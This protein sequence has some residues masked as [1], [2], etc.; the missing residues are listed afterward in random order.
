MKPYFIKDGDIWRLPIEGSIIS[1]CLVDM[2]FTFEITIPDN[3][4][5][6]SVK[7]EE[8]FVFK[9]LDKE[10]VLTP[11]PSGSKE[12]GPVLN[13]L[14]NKVY[15]ISIEKHGELVIESDGNNSIRVP[16]SAEFEAWSI[17]GPNGLLVVCAPDGEIS[18]WQPN[19][20]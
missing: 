13:I 20:T 16:A 2:A 9:S 11:G 12:V 3:S 10:Y 15:N 7:I 17:Y 14:W 4:V 19:E 1:R 5:L 18:I 8:K 6:I